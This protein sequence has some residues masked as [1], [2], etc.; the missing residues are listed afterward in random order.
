MADSK[1]RQTGGTG[2]WK[3]R[4]KEREKARGENCACIISCTFNFFFFPVFSNYARKLQEDIKYPGDTN[5]IIDNP[6]G[7]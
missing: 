5:V 6:R 7:L 1:K 2:S 3:E 4:K